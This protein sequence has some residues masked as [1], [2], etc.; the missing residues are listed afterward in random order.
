[1]AMLA[2]RTVGLGQNWLG[3][4]ESTSGRF[5][6]TGPR[7]QS[8]KQEID[9]GVTHSMKT[10]GTGIAG[11]PG[12]ALA[13]WPGCKCDGNCKLGYAK[14][15]TERQEELR[16]ELC[17]GKIGL[18]SAVALTAQPQVHLSGSAE[19][20]EA[21]ATQLKEEAKKATEEVRSRT[22][23]SPAAPGVHLL[24]ARCW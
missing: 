19:C 15:E 4:T 9:S 8:F 10:F 24:I 2:A 6:P 3:R 22:T 13:P 18:P 20:T 11:T 17:R 16:A 23:L 12:A 21:L 7:L 1:M 5:V 14:N